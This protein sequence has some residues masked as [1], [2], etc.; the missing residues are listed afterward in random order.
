[1]AQMPAFP[2]CAIVGGGMITQVQI[3]P[4]IYQL[5]RQGLLGEI[6][7]SALNGAPLK[8]LA[9]DP[10]LRDAFPGQSFTP[11]P[12]FRKVDL[13]EKFPDLFE[14]VLASL[15]ERNLVVVALP[16]QLHYRAIKKALEAG[17]HVMTVKPLVLRYA[18][19]VELEELARAKGLFVGVEYHKR[20][21]DRALL[22]RKEYRRGN[23]GEFR[24]AQATMIE[25]Y[26]YRHSNFQNWCTVENSDM[27][28][29][30]GC[31]YVDQVAFITGL[32]PVEVSVYGIV[33]EYPNGNQ[34][35]LWTDGRVIW[36][37]G[38]SLSILDA[39][40][41]PN[42]APGGNAQHLKM[43]CQGDRDACLLAHDDQFRGVKYSFNTQGASEGEDK[44]YHEPSPDY[45]K[46]LYRGG[47]GLEPVG[48][49]FRSIEAVVRAAARV[50]AAGASLAARRAAIEEIDREGVIAT[51]ANSSYN[52]L[53]IEAGR[54]SIRNRGR[55]VEI[56]YG[57]TPGVRFK[58]YA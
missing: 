52:E 24:L 49:G 1:M 44:F 48:Y 36:E 27:F 32:L 10:T 12:D 23:F 28:T 53:V 19:A 18:Q 2:V 39:I 15:P 25:P 33:D 20:F 13:E 35:Y 51:P 11:F 57:K 41:Y 54:L 7:I 4:S 6:R 5:Q 34:G 42:A 26:Y 21:D 29:Y 3:L 47:K 9:E 31:H 43:F 46:L 58:P 55:A 40:G 37:N 17:Q 50:N 38:A 14:T 56:V 8:V 30:V 45:F 16:D 22:A